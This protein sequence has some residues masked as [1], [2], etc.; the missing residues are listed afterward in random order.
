MRE[1][2]RYFVNC[3]VL[4]RNERWNDSDVLLFKIF[5]NQFL[6]ICLVVQV[7]KKVQGE[8]GSQLFNEFWEVGG[9]EV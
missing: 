4:S 1:S 9:G 2:Y 7:I 5:G 3:K 8:L 6:F